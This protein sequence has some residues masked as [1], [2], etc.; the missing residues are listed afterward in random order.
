MKETWSLTQI[1][2]LAAE[3]KEQ[4]RVQQSRIL[5]QTLGI[6]ANTPTSEFLSVEV[7]DGVKSRDQ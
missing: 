5:I 1:S 2:E 4:G 3:L 7:H 6:L